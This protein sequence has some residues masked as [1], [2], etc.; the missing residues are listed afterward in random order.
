[1][2]K[3]LGSKTGLS[4]CDR[5]CSSTVGSSP[6]ARNSAWCSDTKPCEQRAWRF[7][8]VELVFL[9]SWALLAS[10]Q[11]SPGG[12]QADLFDWWMSHFSWGTFT[13]AWGGAPPM[14]LPDQSRI[15]FRRNPQTC[16]EFE[17]DSSNG[18]VN[19]Q[20]CVLGGREGGP[21]KVDDQFCP[22]LVGQAFPVLLGSS[23]CWETGA[24]KQGN[25]TSEV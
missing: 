7:L 12:T 4:R 6:I 13:F 22:D 18:A 1:M 23:S 3:F 14:N 2:G 20:S 24:T 9:K 15:D 5:A 10:A 11:K 16:L 8:S 19:A 21:R 17:F 25:V